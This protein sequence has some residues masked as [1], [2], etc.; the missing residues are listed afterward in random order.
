MAYFDWSKSTWSAAGTEPA[1]GD[2][3]TQTT[4]VALCNQKEGAGILGNDAQCLL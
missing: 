3:A 4:K 1:P 2:N